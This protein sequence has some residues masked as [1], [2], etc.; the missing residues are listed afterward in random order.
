MRRKR[1][2]LFSSGAIF[3]SLALGLLAASAAQA[4]QFTLSL[5]DGSGAPVSGF[6]WVLQQ[7]TTFA[8]DPNTPA[9]NAD[10]M[11]SLS[12]HASNQPVATS[13]TLTE[14]LSGNTDLSSV[15]VLDVPTGRYYVSVL[16]YADHSIGGAP[17]DLTAG[18]TEVTVTVQNHP[19]PTAQI[20]IFLFQD[21]WPVNGAPDLPEEE[22]PGADGV[23]VDWSQFSI[24]LEEPAGRYGAA[25]GQVIQDAFSNPLGTVY[26]DTCDETG[27]NPGTGTSICLD[28]N[29]DPVVETL[30]DGTL[31]P[32]ALSGTLLVKNLAPGK[33]G[34]I[35][36][37]PTGQGWQQTSTI[38]GTKVIDAWVKANEPPFFVE[39]GFPGPHVFVGFVQEFTDPALDGT[40][41]ITGTITDMHMS[42]PPNFE[43]FS[44][45]LF[46]QCWVALNEGGAVPGKALF[47][48]PCDANSDFLIPGVPEGSYT[49]TIF[50]ANLDVVIATQPVTVDAL[51]GCNG[52]VDCVLGEI[53]VFN[54]FTRLNT[55]IFNDLDQDG[56]WD[57]T[58]GP[59]ALDSGPVQIRWRDGTI[60]QFFGTDSEGF[61]P[62]DEV[63]PFFHWLVAEVGFG[64]NK[65]TGATFVVDAGGLV[66]TTTD[67]FPGFGEL[68]PQ[69]Q[70]TSHDP[71][72]GACI[73]PIDNPNTG[74]NLSRT[75]TG[76]VLTQA[77]Q[78]FLGQTSVIQF[79]TAS[80]TVFTP[81]V[82]VPLTL[83]Q[84]VGE[85]GGISGMVIYATTRNEDDPE[86][87][88]VEE[89]EP[90]VP[91][92]QVA[93]YADG[94][95]NP[96]DAVLPPS[97]P[98]LFPNGPGDVDWNGNGLFD[99]NDLIIDDVDRNGC[100]GP[101]DVDNPPLGN[102][103]GPEDF[104]RT[105]TDVDLLVDTEPCLEGP[106][107]GVVLDLHDAIQITW[108][109]SW[110]DSLPTGCQGVNNTPAS[111]IDPPVADD[112][113]FDG[114]RNF[115]QVRPGVF[116]GGWA[117]D[118]YALADLPLDVETSLTNF[119][120]V[121]RSIA[122]PGGGTFGDILPEEWLL[123]ADYIVETS[124]PPGYKLM[125][126]H[127][128]NVDFGDDYIPAVPQA[129]PAICVGDPETVPQYLA[130]VTKDGSGTDPGD[131]SNLTDPA[132]LGDPDAFAPFALTDR[133][134]CDRK[135]VPLS[136]AQNA[137]ADFFVMTDVPIAGNVSGMILNDLANEFNP[138][139]PA[140]GEKYAPPF[141][142][143]G[144][145]DWNGA[146]V[147]RIY[148]DQYG[149]FNALLPSTYTAN[150]PQP[151]GMS[152]NMIVSCMNDAG[153]IPNPAFDPVTNPDVPEFIVDPFF[154]PQF[155]QFCYTFQYMPGAIT[156]L[157]T[158]VESVAAFANPAEN[159]VDCARPDLTPVI[160][161]VKRGEISGGGG[162]FVLGGGQPFA[163]EQVEITSVGVVQVPNPEWDGV[164]QTTRFITR[165]YTF[166]GLENVGVTSVWLEDA[167]GNRTEQTILSSFA[168][169]Q[170]QIVIEVDKNTPPGDYQVILN[171]NISGDA[172]NPVLVESPIGV[173]L[174]VGIYDPTNC[175][176]G[177]G[178]FPGECGVKPNADP[179]DGYDP[180]E[181]YAVH[182]VGAGGF[183]SIQE[184]IDA[185]APADM[186]LVDPGIYDELVVMWK[187]VKLQG[188][189]AGVVTLN[190]RQV[191]TEKIANWRIKVEQLIADGL[192]D[193]LPGQDLPL[194]GFPAL[195]APV[196]A[197]EEGAGIFVAG[198]RVGLRRFGREENRGARIDGFTIVGA[199]QG[200]AI[201]ANGYNQ[202][203]RITNNRLT[204]NAGFFGGGL[205]VGHPTLTVD[206][207]DLGL[208]HT[209]AVN[210]R[211]IV[212]YNHIAQNGNTF[213]GA[214]AGISLH[215]GADAYRVQKNWICGN[216][217]KGDGAGIGHLGLS[218][219]G[220][221][222][223]NLVIFNESFLQAGPV[224]GSGIF[225]GGKPGLQPV[226][227]GGVPLILSPGSGTV[228]ID[229]NLIR[230]NLAGAGDGGGI[231][232][233]QANGLD[234]ANSLDDIGP[235]YDVLVYNNMINNNVAGLAGGG[236]SVE[237]SLRVVIRHNT[238]ANN[239]STATT[240]LAF[241]LDPNQ[242]VP[243][244]AGIV[245]RVHSTDVALL[246]TEV[247][248]PDLQT[249]WLT[250]S[251]PVLVSNIVYQN[252]SFFWLNFDDPTTAIIETGLYP[253]SDVCLLGAPDPAACDL[254]LVDDYTDDFG[255]LSGITDTG[256][257]LD[258]R[259][260]LLS[261]TAENQLNYIPG[262]ANNNITGD[263][264]FVNPYFNGAR[265]A[266][267][268]PEFKTLQTAGAFDEGGNFIQVTYAPLSLLELDGDITTPP[269]PLLDYHIGPAS[270]A[271]DGAGAVATITRLF[272]DFD[273]DPRPLGPAADIGADEL[274]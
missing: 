46:P 16:P 22:N 96:P 125:R 73:G 219:F 212:R 164:D 179:T 268:I 166:G 225:I 251:D 33:Y 53:A 77:F 72:T 118:A 34:V 38:E 80:Y 97:L 7:D 245:S 57:A 168:D 138:N 171:R 45:R 226:D 61:A 264:A 110:D 116:D 165:D 140:F 31:H 172:A 52:G 178:V 243:H 218:R 50:D 273:N 101:A 211:I 157:D 248:D 54:W 4:A 237:D 260:A 259:R 6:R 104:D 272:L 152:P 190:A 39:F 14:G 58:E 17:V 255:V 217:S 169:S 167:D 81:L 139:S 256:N 29:G 170:T 71:I 42:R 142:P 228:T 158:P 3:G 233:H 196:F 30:G 239:D 197:T 269:G 182:K 127:H 98:P 133:P 40:V 188:W 198:N 236:I 258:P 48:A 115:N 244:P 205:R 64:R 112:R 253:A 238:I 194:P 8:V 103:P 148:A 136:A 9:T 27:A 208:I 203:L 240:A 21:N 143:V 134:L 66:D 86:L 221:I 24:I 130:M 65:I 227:V 100:V 114:L 231:R 78:G 155:S 265:D 28:A 84:Y 160:A 120:T 131:G 105:W 43:F 10:D 149:R 126:E 199:S 230:G 56:F 145:Y 252:R 49:I 161:Q 254:A 191:P 95:I 12:F 209:D 13:A 26:L 60:Y 85:N 266:L 186:I 109:D 70:C 274:Q 76:P 222:E 122:R 210:D 162:P 121:R 32:D 224:N 232:V 235:W 90:G 135:S 132:F 185:A 150:L 187:P 216:F 20:A 74:D 215:T 181:L 128:K 151:S 257:L 59:A 183:V 129:F 82:P 69:E 15:D 180:S 44:G 271:I 36:V 23:L 93:L 156:Y 68:T 89:W 176:V 174:T 83:P 99:S 192:I 154:N 250:F 37:P 91:R 11:L 202:D 223:D 123:P 63:F 41:D 189:G 214:G 213:G 177:N 117:F 141:V 173:T 19:I 5:V 87:G 200:G 119:Y 261:N 107:D 184:A 241:D 92:V 206:D 234:I 195:G 249:D 35:V 113:C 62:F 246:M 163:S 1:S 146:E 204:A 55:A 106:G 25:G 18:D 242:S 94:D 147:N 263:P 144:F 175:P 229:A 75:E 201:V 220:V 137:A 79:G 111:T 2:H 159:P 47:A 153:P 270:D 51:G 247:T 193:I 267:A 108:T 207:P 88:V 262:V 124:T 67:A 102:F